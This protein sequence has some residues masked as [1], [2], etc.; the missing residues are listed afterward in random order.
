MSK[1]PTVSRSLAD[2]IYALDAAL[3]AEFGP[4][5]QFDITA[6]GKRVAARNTELSA[7]NP[8][9]FI[10]PKTRRPPHGPQQKQDPPEGLPL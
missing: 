1:R 10:H 3:R 2:C 4:N 9:H 8:D 6:L 5:Y 7:R